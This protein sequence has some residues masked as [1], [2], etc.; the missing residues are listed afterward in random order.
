MLSSSTPKD[1]LASLRSF[2][3]MLE[4][5]TERTRVE[6]ELK[7]RGRNDGG[8]CHPLEVGLCF[9][10]FLSFVHSQREAPG[11]QKLKL[12]TLN[13]STPKGHTD[14]HIHWKKKAAS[15][16]RDTY[17]FIHMFEVCCWSSLYGRGDVGYRRCVE[18]T[19]EKQD[20]KRKIRMKT[21]QR[22]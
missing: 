21:R 6:M 18:P 22:Q 9:P 14:T 10:C 16:Y 1:Y 2:S 20:I 15:C 3:Q 4:D 5:P 12:E 13:R 17:F 7:P 19:H 11:W 8:R